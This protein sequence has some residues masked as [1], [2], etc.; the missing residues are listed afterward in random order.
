[1]NVL[2]GRLNGDGYPRRPR[3]EAGR[4]RAAFRPRAPSGR[5]SAAS[6]CGRTGITRLR[7]LRPCIT[8]QRALR[9]KRKSCFLRRASNVILPGQYYDLETGLNYN[10]YRDYDP[11]SGRYVESDPIGLRGGVNTYAFVSDAPIIE[12]DANGLEAVS[13]LLQHPPGPPSELPAPELPS[14]AKKYYCAFINLCHGNRACAFRKIYDLRHFSPDGDSY[15]FWNIPVM[16]DAEN[17]GL[18][19]S[20]SAWDSA[21]ETSYIG[22]YVWQFHKVASGLPF[23]HTS[24]YSNDALNSGLAGKDYLG[25]SPDDMLKW[26]NNCG[27]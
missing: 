25:K 17:F 1:M 5:A 21:G 16:R 13:Y 10:Y 20:V 27:N 26:C 23:V 2:P 12:E 6:G 7:Q 19:A 24:P 3:P 11:T 14:D 18:T 4:R 22:V 9:E 8:A 15:P